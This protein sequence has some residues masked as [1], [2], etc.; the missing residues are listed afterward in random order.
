M[1][2][3]WSASATAEHAVFAWAMRQLHNQPLLDA[4]VLTDKGEW[5]AQ[6]TVQL[7]PEELPLEDLMR[8]WDALEP[9]YRLSASYVARVVNIGP[10]EEEVA[11]PVIATR[12]GITQQTGKVR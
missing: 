3:V 10:V 1:L 11:G 12:F 2:T 7:I 9:S 8:V 5:T 6:E 4:S